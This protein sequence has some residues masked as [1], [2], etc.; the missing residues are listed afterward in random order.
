MS[1][2]LAIA[3]LRIV[4]TPELGIDHLQITLT[5]E[6]KLAT[7]TGVRNE[8]DAG[9]SDGCETTQSMDKPDVIITE[10]AST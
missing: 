4:T 8:A 5:S 7:A 9:N 6:R 3:E 1:S 10:A 2:E